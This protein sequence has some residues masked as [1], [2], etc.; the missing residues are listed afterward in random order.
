MKSAALVSAAALALAALAFADK[1]APKKAASADTSKSNGCSACKEK[2]PVLDPASLSDDDAAARP[3]YAIA[4]KYP[5]TIDK[6]HCY[7]GCEDSPNLH[8]ASLLTCYTSLHATGCEICRGEAE[9]A[10]KMK[11]EGSSDEEVKKVV[12]AFY[13]DQDR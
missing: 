13:S 1:P 7:C 4:Q 2:N 10:G 11:N 12:E 8:H 9:M 6:I 5:E 3:A